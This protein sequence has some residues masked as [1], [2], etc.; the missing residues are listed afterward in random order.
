[1]IK[2][3][4]ISVSNKEGIAEFAKELSEL[5]IKIISTG[6]TSKILEKNNVKATRISEVTKFPEMLDG[7]VK[8]LHPNVFAGILADR[9]S[10]KH[11]GELKKLNIKAIDLVVVNFYPFEETMKSNSGLGEIIEN[12]DIGG[13]SLV[14]AASKNHEDVLVVID[15][16]DYQETIKRIKSKQID[17]KFRKNL[18][19]KAFLQTAR[20]DTIIGRYFAEHFLN[21][22]LPDIYNFTFRKIQDLRYGENPHQKAAFYRAYWIDESC[23]S[24]SKQLH[25]KELSYNNILDANDAFELIKDFKDPTAAVIK[26]TN[27][28][29]VAS[30]KKIEA[31]YKK[32]HE[33]D[34]K[35]AFGCVI[36][37]NKPCNAETAKVM[38]PLF[39]EVVI[40]PSFEKVALEILKAKKNI[41]LLET[42]P[43]TKNYKSPDMKRVIG[44]LLVQTRQ[45]PDLNEK[46]LKV[47]TKRK[48]TKEELKDLIFAWK[49]NKHVKSNSVVFV[50]DDVTVGIGAGQ[51]SRVDA[52]NIAIMKNEEKIKGSVMSSDAF[53]PFRDGVDQA[54]KA[55]VTAIIQPGGSIRDEEVIKAADEHNISMVFTGIRLFKH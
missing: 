26:H 30:A 37:L 46:D 24:T 6:N 5:G 31:A 42:G 34:P 3:A 1:M 51:M 35:S 47:V 43:I 13:P 18:A 50:K 44:G 23:V 36:A 45:Y 8:T 19:T 52:V 4:L 7:R 33:A 22:S 54:A 48:P 25:G 15:P 40:C 53:F 28:S 38:K 11:M 10:K 29:G 55:G 17:Q 21:D 32:A 20:Y 12:I 39:I 14:R 2:T 41:R 27:P 16:K 9:K 49:V